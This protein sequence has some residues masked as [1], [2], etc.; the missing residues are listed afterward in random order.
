ML[1]EHKDLLLKDL[2]NRIPYGVKVKIDTHST[3]Y[4]LKGIIDTEYGGRQGQLL[5]KFTPNNVSPRTVNYR[6]DE[7]K[8]YLIPR[9]SLT[10]EQS[11]EIDEIMESHN[12]LVQYCTELVE[13][14]DKNHIDYRGLIP[15]GLAI[16]ATNLNIY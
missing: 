7:F 16:D 15:L 3:T 13:F 6:L 1:Q 12:S 4:I 10:E 5:D 9:S 11:E 14:Y 8:P 2:C